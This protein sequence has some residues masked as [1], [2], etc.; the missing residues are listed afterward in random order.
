MLTAQ[1]YSA[2]ELAKLFHHYRN[3]LAE[4]F[5]CTEYPHSIIWERAPENERKLMV[6]AARLALLEL[7]AV[8]QGGSVEHH[9]ENIQADPRY[10]SRPGEVEWG[11]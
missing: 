5:E 7:S 3:A 8:R 10:F 11:C 9:T 1:E 6:A 4:D 2:E